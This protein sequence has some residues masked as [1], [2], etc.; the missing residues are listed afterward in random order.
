MFPQIQ[1]QPPG[2]STAAPITDQVIV[3]RIAEVTR[4]VGRAPDG[5]DGKQVDFDDPKA[6]SKTVHLTIAQEQTWPA[7]SQRD[8]LEV[9]FAIGGKSDFEMTRAG[10]KALG[11]VVLFLHRGSPVFDYKEN[12]LG[13]HWNGGMIAT[14]SDNGALALPFLESPIDNQLLTGVDTLDKLTDH[15][16]DPERVIRITREEGGLRREG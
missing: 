16:D 7:A 13:I 10:L 2:K 9:G 11:R 4:G 1:Y 5:G 15:S 8:N 3:G 12:L 14:I 6:I